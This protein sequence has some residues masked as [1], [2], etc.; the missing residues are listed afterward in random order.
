VKVKKEK[1][2][3]YLQKC[4]DEI[5]TGIARPKP[6]RKAYEYDGGI[7]ALPTGAPVP[8]KKHQKKFESLS[9]PSYVLNCGGTN[10]EGVQINLQDGK[11]QISPRVSEISFHSPQRRVRDSIEDFAEE[12]ADL[13]FLLIGKST[14]HIESLAIVL[15]FAQE[16]YETDYGIEA[17]F[18]E[19]QLA[20]GWYVKGDVDKPIGRLLID[21]LKAKYHITLDKVFFGNDAALMMWDLSLE[22]AE[23]E[24]LAPIGGVWGSGV[25]FGITYNMKKWQDHIINTEI[26]HARSLLTA[27]DYTD[28]QDMKAL[29]CELPN[30]PE[31]ETFVAGD[32]LFYLFA[33]K[34]I[35][36]APSTIT[37]PRALE[38][39]FAE[40]IDHKGN[41]HLISEIIASTDL[42]EIPEILNLRR[43][44]VSDKT[45]KLIKKVAHEVFDNATLKTALIITAF[46]KVVDLAPSKKWVIPIEGSVI[47]KGFNIYENLC[48]IIKKQL[49]DYDIRIATE[50]TSK[51][52]LAIFSRVLKTE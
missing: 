33:T 18:L 48:K 19:N 42:S 23:D 5:E 38:N 31:I 29:G 12:I 32:Y 10:W 6:P 16:N 34:V 39:R 3:E 47:N 27:Q 15:G 9:G 41:S 50:G 36:S 40:L 46:V 26:G 43:D 21:I 13:L 8:S 20:K 49:P 7:L 37:I 22:V 1:F 30:A 44:T 17:K 35:T 25:N 2:K 11:A 45:L 51:N 52:A 28:F 4:I 14:Q 24:T